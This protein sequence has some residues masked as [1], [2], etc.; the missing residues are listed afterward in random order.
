MKLKL[1]AALMIFAVICTGCSHDGF[2]TNENNE[3]K[4]V[5]VEEIEN[6]K[7]KC[8]V[9]VGRK[10]DQC[11]NSLSNHLKRAVKIEN[12]KICLLYYDES[13]AKI[14]SIFSPQKL[15]S[16]YV[17]EN[18]KILNSI[19]Y[20]DE[21]DIENMSAIE[22]TEYTTKVRKKITEFVKENK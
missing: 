14:N 12:T 20:Y 1:Y 5:T 4:V 13:Q 21:K 6:E 10:D 3:I 19:E 15:P 7:D 2:F 9:I 11:T 17:V 18:N 8:F 16:L 22:Q